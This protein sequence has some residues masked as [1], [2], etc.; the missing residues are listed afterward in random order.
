[1][2]NEVTTMAYCDDCH[3][4]FDTALLYYFAGGYYCDGCLPH[5]KA[6]R[7]DECERALTKVEEL[8][9]IAGKAIHEGEYLLSHG[10]PPGVTRALYQGR[11]EVWKRVR[12]VLEGR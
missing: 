3:E 1:M 6:E 2:S 7:A 8:R 4:P 11:L 5:A 10:N 9:Y 12:E